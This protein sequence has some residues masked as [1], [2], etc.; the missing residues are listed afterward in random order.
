MSQIVF[1]MKANK[2]YDRTVS[3]MIWKEGSVDVDW[4][5]S[6]CS[7]IEYNSNVIVLEDFE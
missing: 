3:A 2:Q 1:G 7:M 5:F 4:E 6:V